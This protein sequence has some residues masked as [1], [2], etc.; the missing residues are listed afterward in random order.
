MFDNGSKYVS[1]VINDG[2]PIDVQI[3]M[4]K[5]IEVLKDTIEHLDYLQVFTI[6]TVDES[7]NKIRI[8]HS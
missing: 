4:C 2:I 5:L 1:R 3:F 7:E 8:I 6:S